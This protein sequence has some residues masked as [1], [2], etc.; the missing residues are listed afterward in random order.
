MPVKFRRKNGFVL[1]IVMTIF[2]SLGILAFALSFLKTGTIEQLGKNVDQNRLAVIAQ[3][4]N[5][6]A[7]AFY[8]TSVNSPGTRIF[9][10]WQNIFETPDIGSLPQCRGTFT[11]DENDPL[12]YSKQ[13]CDSVPGYGI[14]L[15]TRVSMIVTSKVNTLRAPAYIGHLELLSQASDRKGNIFEIKERR[16][17]KLV[18]LR[19]FFDKYVFYVK[20]YSFDY[21]Q[22][23]RHLILTGFP[24]SRVDWANGAFSRA[25]IGNRFFPKTE[26]ENLIGGPD[27][28]PI[29]L[30]IDHTRPDCFLFLN[31]L[32]GVNPGEKSFDPTDF[33]A[34]TIAQN[35]TFWVKDPPISF[36]TI[37]GISRNELYEYSHIKDHYMKIVKAAQNAASGI[38]SEIKAQSVAGVIL[39]DYQKA[40]GGDYSNCQVFQG[41]VQ[42]FIDNWKYF[43]GYTS[44]SCLWNLD[45]P[46]L[47]PKD[48]AKFTHFSGL[49]N[50]GPEL[51]SGTPP[52]NVEKFRIGRMPY[53]YG[54]TGEN[55]ILFEGNL[56]L[57]FFKMAF[58]DEF[59]TKLSAIIPG[60][61]QSKSS[62]QELQVDFFVSAISLDFV[63]P[64]STVPAAEFLRKIRPVDNTSWAPS[65]K[66]R[67]DSTDQLEGPL[68]S[69][70]IDNIPVN[71]LLPT[72]PARSVPGA[73]AGV[74]PFPEQKLIGGK[75]AD[76]S[77][78]FPHFDLLALSFFYKTSQDFLNERVTVENGQKVLNLDGKIFIEMGDLKLDDVKFFRGQGTV[79]LGTGNCST[80][81]IKRLPA[82]TAPAT[83]RIFLSAGDF[84][85]TGSEN[86]VY[87][88]ASLIALFQAPPDPTKTSYQGKLMPNNHNVKIKGNLIVDFFFTESGGN[89]LPINGEIEIEHDE[90]IFSPQVPGRITVGT[91]KTF[92]SMNAAGGSF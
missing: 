40:A 63:T 32:L 2:I 14:K 3:A 24:Q 50:Y 87:I 17:L 67:L 72:K 77:R 16:D 19:D 54:R 61:L 55:A 4:A 27:K 26:E 29:L 81:G 85:I 41:I 12:P 90:E 10:S 20:N 59:T 8:K 78:F 46:G 43:Y 53:I 11:W 74:F 65:V 60:A 9:N 52:F 31:E 76:G 88:E 91:A 86:P 44:A 13:I 37:T 84:V 15:R 48:F 75:Y 38:D 92:F 66:P 23:Q 30:D 82:S 39:D 73:P 89:G 70:A 45:D 6:E 49:T 25:F 18:D 64:K 83:M 33:K 57:R 34:K 68:M 22:P 56:F 36:N 80:S 1:L 58:F 71:R 7:L 79:I 28:L 47:P 51:T 35:S 21:N 62:P 42:T 5:N 69:R